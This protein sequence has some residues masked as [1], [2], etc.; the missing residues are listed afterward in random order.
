MKPAELTQ[1]ISNELPAMRKSERKVGQFVLAHPKEVIRMRIVDLANQAEVSEPTVVRFCRAVGCEGFQDFKL[2]L[3]QQLASS[4]SIG[5][6]AVTD[7]DSTAQY[8]F[9]VFDSTVDSLLK[10]RDNLD[11]EM[12]DRAVQALC[13]AQRVEFYGFGASAAVAFD[14]QHRFFRLQLATAAYSDPHLQNMSATSLSPDDVVVAFSQSG[15]TRALL[16]SIALVKTRGAKVIA[17]APSNSPVADAATIPITIDVKEDIQIYTPMSSRIA[18]LAVIDVLAIGL[19]QQKGPQL[20]EHLQQLQA[21][22]NSL[23]VD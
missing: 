17:L 3:A 12:L 22:L 21:N 4:P 20:E 18:H 11:L 23:R 15:R 16:D 6:I 13:A 5:Q 7:S 2:A 1:S 19:A 9:K 10:V 14:A 8:S